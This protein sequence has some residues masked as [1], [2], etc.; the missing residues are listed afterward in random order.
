MAKK[1]KSGKK[2]EPLTFRERLARMTR[3][4]FYA[5]ARRTA[6]GDR[7][8]RAAWFARI[9]DDRAEA[10]EAALAHAPMCESCCDQ[11]SAPELVMAAYLVTKA[12]ELS[13][14]MVIRY[15]TEP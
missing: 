12:L 9:D 8:H 13:Q 4:E 11:E 2:V 10:L 3:E 5:A 7:T 15:S 6:E 14:D 1:R